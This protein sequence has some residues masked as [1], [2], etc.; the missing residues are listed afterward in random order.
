MS[1]AILIRVL[2]LNL[3][4]VLMEQIG[5]RTEVNGQI[6]PTSQLPEQS[7][8]SIGKEMEKLTTLVLFRNARTESFILLR[9]TQ[10]ILAEPKLT[11]LD[12]HLFMVTVFRHIK[13]DGCS[14]E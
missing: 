8:S 11:V 12:L 9:A 7:S 4:F 3:L 5:S 1:V 6:I 10:E 14:C 13:K 2:F